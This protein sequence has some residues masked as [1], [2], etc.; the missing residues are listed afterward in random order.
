MRVHPHHRD[1]HFVDLTGCK[2]K[3]MQSVHGT[4]TWKRIRIQNPEQ[5]L[6]KAHHFLVTTKW[7]LVSGGTSG[8]EGSHLN[9]CFYLKT[10]VYVS[11]CSQ[12]C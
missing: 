11:V 5:L 8:K 12:T 4:I 7:D 9:G 6:P 2:Q 3:N 10:V 1:G